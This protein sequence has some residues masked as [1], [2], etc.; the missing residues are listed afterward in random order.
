MIKTTNEIVRE[1]MNECV[2][3][4][5]EKYLKS[6]RPIYGSSELGKP[7]HI[8][9]CVL[10]EINKEKYLITAAHVI[11]HNERTTLYT[12]GISGT[13]ELIPIECENV[14]R[15]KSIDGTRKNDRFDFAILPVSENMMQNMGSV[16][17][18]NESDIFNHEPDKGM[19]LALGF[20]NSKNKKPNNREK[21]VSQNPF[22]YSSHIEKN[23]DIFEKIGVNP[24]SHYLLDF[25][26]RHSKDELGNMVNS[27][28]P[29][30]ASGGGLF[31]ITGM[32]NPENLIPR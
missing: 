28:C 4:L 10:L 17:F 22:I 27:I 1:R 26:S 25:C 30:G 23:S 2:D 31:F 8:G 15:T 11:D 19:Y 24:D 6:V 18:L 20:P 21:K 13:D 12:S 32:N 9:S 14:I 3:F 16:I 7:E 29:Q 5:S